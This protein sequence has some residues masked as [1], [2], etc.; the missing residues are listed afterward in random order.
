[1]TQTIETQYKYLNSLASRLRA[2]G[3][4]ISVSKIKDNIFSIALKRL[5]KTST[6]EEIVSV[7]E[8][9]KESNS[10]KATRQPKAKATKKAARQP[11][12]K[13][14]ELTFEDDD[15]PF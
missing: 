4:V 12:A 1:M 11:N 5:P 7:Q 9:K 3:A 14:K 6:V 10:E 15:I 13:A 8:D 2:S